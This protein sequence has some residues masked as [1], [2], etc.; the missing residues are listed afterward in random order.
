MKL[1]EIKNVL[2]TKYFNESKT[3]VSEPESEALLV[4]AAAMISKEA[5]RLTA[6]ILESDSDGLPVATTASKAFD[7]FSNGK[8][9]T[10]VALDESVNPTKILYIAVKEYRNCAHINCTAGS[11]IPGLVSAG[12]VKTALNQL[13]ELNE[14]VKFRLGLK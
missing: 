7:L 12:I 9:N 5:S 10:I 3:G 2:I 13:E 14:D 11:P 1:Q 8:F 6:L 4:N